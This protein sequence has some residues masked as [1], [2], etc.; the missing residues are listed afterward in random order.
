MIVC[1]LNCE[2]NLLKDEFQSTGKKIKLKGTSDVNKDL[3][4][5]YLNSNLYVFIINASKLIGWR[6]VCYGTSIL[7]IA[8]INL[9]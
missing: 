7:L 8:I 2:P 4:K 1:F 9:L 5:C 6:V 3:C